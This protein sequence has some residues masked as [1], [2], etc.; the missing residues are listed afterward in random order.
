MMQVLDKAGIQYLV[1]QLGIMINQRTPFIAKTTAEWNADVTV[2]SQP[3]Y[4]YI[5]TDYKTSTKNGTTI[6]I[7][8]IKFGTGN[9]FVVDLPFLGIDDEAIWSHINNGNIHV[10]SEEKA[11]WNNKVTVVDDI[12]NETLVLS[13]Q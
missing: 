6:S 8:G 9:A 3:G 7:P 11:F 5:Y 4:I 13:R 10:T 12:T 2:E 1:S